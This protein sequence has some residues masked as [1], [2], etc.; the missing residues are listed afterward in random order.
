MV[1]GDGLTKSADGLIHGTPN[2]EQAAL[3]MPEKAVGMLPGEPRI[4]KL[5]KGFELRHV[6]GARK[7]RRRIAKRARESYLRITFH[8]IQ[9]RLIP[10]L[11]KH[12]PFATAQ[13]DDERGIACL[14][15]FVKTW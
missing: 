5:G 12:I 4:P 2:D 10:A 15:S 6:I 13:V 3:D 11:L 7:I 8:V 9:E 14:Q 1:V